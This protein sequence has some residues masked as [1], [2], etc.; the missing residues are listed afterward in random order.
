VQLTLSQ[1]RANEGREK[2]AK[3]A[4]APAQNSASAA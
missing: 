4:K 2:A 3:A 1:M